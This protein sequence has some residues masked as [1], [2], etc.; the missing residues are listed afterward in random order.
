MGE[1][2]AQ[3]FEEACAA[4]LLGDTNYDPKRGTY[5]GC[6]LYESERRARASYG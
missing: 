2:V 1:A 4:V 5:W 3:T 6:R